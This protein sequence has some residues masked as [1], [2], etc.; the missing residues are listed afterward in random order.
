MDSLINVTYVFRYDQQSSIRATTRMEFA[1]TTGG[2]KCD[3]VQSIMTVKALDII[4]GQTS[5]DTMNQMKE[6]MAKMVA[7][8]KMTW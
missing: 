3:T 1:S 8:I 7:A 4:I 5:T 2:T 6:K